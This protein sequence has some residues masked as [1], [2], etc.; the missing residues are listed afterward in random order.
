MLARRFC[1]LILCGWDWL[2]KA[3]FNGELRNRVP[4][5]WFANPRYPQRA[6]GKVCLNDLLLF[7]RD[8]GACLSTI[9][10]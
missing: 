6:E 8:Q 1:Q 4:I 10:V 5:A 7:E 9:V 2:V 3:M